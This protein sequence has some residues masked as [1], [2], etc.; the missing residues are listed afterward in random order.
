MAE[1]ASIVPG[2]STGGFERG[3]RQTSIEESVWRDSAKFIAGPE[4]SPNSY[5]NRQ[6][7]C[8]GL[9][10]DSRDEISGLSDKIV[11]ETYLEAFYPWPVYEIQACYTSDI[12]KPADLQ[13]ARDKLASVRSS[14]FAQEISD[15]VWSGSPSFR[16]S[17]VPL[18]STSYSLT[19][20][21]QRL[22]DARVTAEAPGPHVFHLPSVLEPKASNAVLSSTPDYTIVFDNYVQ[23]YVP[24]TNISGGGA[25]T[26]PT[27]GVQAWIAITGPYEYGFSS[28]ETEPVQ[29]IEAR[30]LNKR[31]I[32]AEQQLFFRYETANTFLA[33]VTL[34]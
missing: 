23:S 13:R 12:V 29:T 9:I 21:M 16:S 3:G 10:D 32:R 18:S 6:S 27:P 1:V 24:D 17:A 25:A 5:V 7:E 11:N 2:P 26:A 28:V 31:L 33:K 8:D 19:E 14:K 34:Y 30:R 15:G 20:A 4:D 22:L